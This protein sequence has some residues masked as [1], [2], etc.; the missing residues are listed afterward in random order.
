MT[1]SQRQEIKQT[2]SLVMTPQLQQAIKLLQLTNIEINEFVGQEIERN[3][4]LEL[5]DPSKPERGDGKIEEV[6]NNIISEKM[7]TATLASKD[8]LP[9]SNDEPLDINYNE[10]L[11]ENGVNSNSS[12]YEQSSSWGTQSSKVNHIDYSDSLEQVIEDKINLTDHLLEQLNADISDP[13]ERLIGYNII[14]MLDSAGYFKS[15][16]STVS[17]IIGCDESKTFEVLEKLKKFDPVGVFAR[18]LSECLTLQLKEKN[19]F[20][21]IIERLIENL[22]LLAKHDEKALLQKCGVSL[23]E[24]IEM[25]EEIKSLNPKPGDLY[26]TDVAQT[27]VPDVFIKKSNDF[28]WSVELN[29]DTLPKVLVNRKYSSLV[30]NKNSSDI[31]RIYINEQLNSAN[32]LVKSLEQRAQTILKVATEIVKQQNEFF[33][34]GIKY[35]KPLTLKDIAEKIE[36]HESTVSRVTSNKYIESPRG[37]FQMKYF[38]T[39]SITTS[40]G[41]SS[42]SSETVKVRIKELIDNEEPDD[43]LSDD[44]I[45]EILIK[46]DI[47]IARRTIAK[48]RESLR[49]PSSVIRRRQKKPYI[50]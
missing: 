43:I 2:Q 25:V 15:D 35:L 41:D 7:D 22:D 23:E 29:T 34:N 39:T 49:I 26:N 9:D 10:Y 31:D 24:L 4:L 30:N 32:W 14:H 44:K 1:I 12:S 6:Q 18:D 37:V 13:G 19:R 47:D 40:H 8:D 48:Y 11:E 46:E 42:L 17:E 20:D 36:M 5:A 27:V 45:V 21:P 3:P 16:I 33:S 50:R 38:F 28:N